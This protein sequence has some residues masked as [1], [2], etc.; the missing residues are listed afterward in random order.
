M[1]TSGYPHHDVNLGFCISINGS[2]YPN[3]QMANAIATLFTFSS[4]MQCHCNKR[5]Y[6]SV[7]ILSN[8]SGMD[9][10]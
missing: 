2:S 6:I 4:I 5:N 7:P 9:S 1:P 10:A 3:R 8:K